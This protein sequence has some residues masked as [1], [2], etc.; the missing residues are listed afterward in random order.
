M[1][2]CLGD[3]LDS[4]LMR[5]AGREADPGLRVGYAWTLFTLG[6]MIGICDP[7]L[8]V[9][10]VTSVILDRALQYCQP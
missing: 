5:V 2:R 8:D 9:C 3:M 10:L 7:K 4:S 6:R 1:E